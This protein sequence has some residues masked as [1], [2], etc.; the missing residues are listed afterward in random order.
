MPLLGLS[1]LMFY[2]G[3]PDANLATGRNVKY[4]LYRQNQQ[5]RQDNKLIAR[6]S[7]KNE[8]FSGYEWGV[9]SIHAQHLAF[10]ILC[11]VVEKEEVTL[12]ARV[13]KRADVFYDK[14]IKVYEPIEPIEKFKVNSKEVVKFLR[15]EC[16]ISPRAFEHL[17]TTG[18]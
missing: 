3:V 6:A 7:E 2:Y 4:D 15:D 17:D 9:A 12:Q 13:L 1:R 8:I 11:N 16:E 14:I 5:L 10:A 18:L